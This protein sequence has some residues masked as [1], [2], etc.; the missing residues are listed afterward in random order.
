MAIADIFEA[1]AA[2]DRPGKESNILSE[3][4]RIIRC[5]C[6]NILVCAYL[7]E[8]FLR[9]DVCRRFGKETCRCC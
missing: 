7:F 5:M 1:I 3:S 8:L 6:N 9:Y 4:I 2:V